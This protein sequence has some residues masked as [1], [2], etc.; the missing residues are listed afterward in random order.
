MGAHQWGTHAVT[1][2]AD[3]VTKRFPA[4]AHERA[5]REWRALTLLDRH[6]PGLAPRPYSCDLGDA[7]PVVS[8]S[9]LP[10]APIRGAPLDGERLTRLARTVNALHSALPAD[11]L[12]RVPVRPEGPAEL[13]AR[14]RGWAP[15]LR[16]RVDAA[17]GA[18]VDAGLA[19][20]DAS[21]LD[22]TEQTAVPA[23]FGPGDGNLANYLWDGSRVRVVDFEDSGR[24]DRAYELAEITEH[25]ASWVE[26][27]LDVAAFLSHVEL[28]AAETVRLRDCRR[29]IALVW[30]FLLSFEDLASGDPA[31]R[32]NPPGTARRQ[33]G[34]L[35]ALLG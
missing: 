25:V 17:V 29:L 15:R 21:G 4:T 18:A 14:L 28:T 32:R 11:V 7:G 35:L 31:A 19:W 13:G 26:H 22:R 24:S 30:L 2:A 9:L 20:L 6:A 34:R 23:V 12:A 1:F 27:P 10:G 16:G 8:M 5:V 3:G 33:A